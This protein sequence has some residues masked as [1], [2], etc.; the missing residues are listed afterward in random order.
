M[1][2]QNPNQNSLPTRQLEKN[3]LR[4]KRVSLRR[5]V[6]IFGNKS[7]AIASVTPIPLQ[8]SMHY[9]CTSGIFE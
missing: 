4:K 6:S 5:T 8:S 9:F 3:F 2:S 7:S 1:I